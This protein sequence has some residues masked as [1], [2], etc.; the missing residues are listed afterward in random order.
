MAFLLAVAGCSTV[1]IG[2][3]D[4]TVSAKVGSVSVVETGGRAGQLYSRALRQALYLYGQ[5]VPAYDLTSSISVSSSSTLSVRGVSST[6]K[7]MT[8]VANFKLTKQGSGDVLLQDTV[9]ADATLGTVSSLFGQDQS[10][11]HARDRMAGL[12]AQRVTQR[13]QLYFLENADN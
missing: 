5:A 6:F 2:Q 12:L 7:K 11:F 9:T 1:T 13:I 8:M 4:E 3:L 10:E